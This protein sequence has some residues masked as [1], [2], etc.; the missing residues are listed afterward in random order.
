M[1]LDSV[2]LNLGHFTRDAVLVTRAEPL[3]KTGPEILWCN[4]AFCD[5]TGYC[6]EDVIGKTPRILQGPNTERAATKR[7]GEALRRWEAGEAELLNYRKDGS[8]FWVSLS[9]VP[10]TD[11]TGW[12]HFWVAVQRDI[13]R[14]R[15]REMLISKYR[16]DLERFTFAAFH[17]LRSPVRAL[18]LLTE[19]A[20]RHVAE[21]ESL[22]REEIGNY[23]SQINKRSERLSN[24]LSESAKYIRASFGRN[25]ER[26]EVDFADMARACYADIQGSESFFLKIDAEHPGLWTSRPFLRVLLYNLMDNSIKHHDRGNGRIV[27]GL[28]DSPGGL[29][30]RV[31]DDGP[32]IPERH[33]DR[34]FE[35]FQSLN[36]SAQNVGSGFGLA[37]VRQLVSREGGTIQ[38]TD[39]DMGG[40]RFEIVLPPAIL[41]WA[42]GEAR[43]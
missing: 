2:I 1:K 43:A 27:V 30:I 39:S 25:D 10:V 21:A 4:Q 12:V 28:C 35:I 13:T 5:M 22:S 34:V 32:G 37:H 42:S 23:L 40:A 6:R 11:E 29:M 3:E 18:R 24:L 17:D 38:V 19:E 20:S 31:E 26:E 7:L 33:R 15:E 9:I 16:N 36:T 14:S 8:T 41:D